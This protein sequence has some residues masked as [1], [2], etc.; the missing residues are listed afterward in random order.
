MKLTILS[1]LLPALFAQAFFTSHMAERGGGSDGSKI[2][3]ELLDATDLSSV[4]NESNEDYIARLMKAVS[5]LSDKEWDKLSKP[6]QD[7]YNDAADAKNDGKSIPAF[8][9]LASKKE[10]TTSRRRSSDKEEDL[11]P[12]VGD[13]IKLVTKRGREVN[14][15]VVEID[16]EVIVL[17]TDD[18]E[19][20]FQ[21]DRIESTHVFHGTSRE[22]ETDDGPADPM[23]VGATVDIKTKRGREATGEIVEITDDLLVLNIDGKEEEFARDRVESIKPKGGKAA[24]SSSRRSSSDDKGDDK[25]A[26]KT[27]EKGKRSSNE[28]V[29]IGV[30]IKE[31]IADNLSASEEDIG[32][33]LKKESLEFKDNTL[34][35]NY[36]DAH[37][38]I[39]ILKAKKLLK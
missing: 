31:L 35:L 5:V 7:W 22:S 14:G 29:S 1:A 19:E 4:R 36:V 16:K 23:G 2:E 11:G 26:G 33:L 20:E 9:D 28:G 3:K 6:A 27:E 37:K 17:K 13:D 38:F 39:S 8:P 10:E 32:K 18:G 34:K 25:G 15:K 30:R 21:R 12:K 24:S